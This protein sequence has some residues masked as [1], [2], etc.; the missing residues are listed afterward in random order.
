MGL[1]A[2]PKSAVRATLFAHLPVALDPELG[3]R[4]LPHADGPARVDAGRRN[5]HLRAEPELSFPQPTSTKAA[6]FS[7]V[8]KQLAPGDR[9]STVRVWDWVAQIP[10]ELRGHRGTVHALAYSPDGARLAQLG[11]ERDGVRV[12][13]A[14]AADPAPGSRFAEFLLESKGVAIVPGAAFHAPEWIRL[15][16]AAPE[17]QVLEGVRQVIAALGR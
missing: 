3:R 12:G 6:A 7:P 10:V 4:E 15:S 16:Y 14:T 17:D 8:G 5:A 9:N 2:P 1:N 11:C 13:P